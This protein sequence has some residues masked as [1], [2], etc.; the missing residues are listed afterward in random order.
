MLK[1]D[2]G[3]VDEVVTT[4]MVWAMDAGEFAYA[5][6]LADYVLRHGLVMPDRFKR[7]TGCLVAEEVAEAALKAQAA[8]KDFDP[9]QLARAASLTEKQDM[10]DEVRAKLF[11]AAGR[12]VIR[13]ATDDSTPALE[14]MQQCVADLTRA[15]ELH[16]ACGGK[17]DLE[18]AERLLK[19][20][21][22]AESTANPPGDPPNEQTGQSG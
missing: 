13:T 21:T 1:A 6:D 17:K 14:A 19:K 11:L 5:L 9:V 2:A 15:I 7:T 22:Q 12:G 8:G 3:A 18:R 4:C 20:L 16:G 10:P